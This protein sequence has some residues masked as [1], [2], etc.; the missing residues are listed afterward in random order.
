MIALILDTE[1][2]GLIAN[3]AVKL[4]KQPEVIEYFSVL[5]NLASGERIHELETLIKPKTPVEPLITE[6]TGIDNLA[7]ADAEPFAAMADAIRH[8]IESS[9][10]V[11]AHNMSFDAEMLN[12]EFERL[13]EQLNWPRQICTVEVTLH[14]KGHRLKL[15]QLHELL[16]GEGF[17]SAHRA[18]TDVEA[19][20]RICIE[21]FKRG[22]L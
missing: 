18:R 5:T 7:L 17:K 2:S 19:L 21:L 8:N 15:M 9:P 12:L 3:H 10:V 4:E 6:I 13:G 11:I 1:T 16:F 14:L 20:E 22:E